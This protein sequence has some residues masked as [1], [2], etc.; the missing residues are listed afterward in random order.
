MLYSY[1]HR[2]TGRLGERPKGSLS[3]AVGNRPALPVEDGALV[4]VTKGSWIHI[5]APDLSIAVI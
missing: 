2:I 4:T 5:H 3:M 1:P